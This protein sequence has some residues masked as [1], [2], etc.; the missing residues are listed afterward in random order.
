MGMKA[1][2]L[3]VC[4]EAILLAS[5]FKYKPIVHKAQSV[6]E[7]RSEEVVSNIGMGWDP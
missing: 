2:V 5:C 3:C 4:I 1:I 7:G 6:L